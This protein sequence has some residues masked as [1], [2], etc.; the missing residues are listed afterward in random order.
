[1]GGGLTPA[2][3]RARADPADQ[4]TAVGEYI[5]TRAS[6]FDAQIRPPAVTATPV[7]GSAGAG[8]RTDS[9]D[10]AAED[11]GGAVNGGG[12][13]DHPLRTPQA[14]CDAKDKQHEG[15]L[16]TIRTLRDAARAHHAKHPVE[17][18]AP[19]ATRHACRRFKAK[20][21][22]GLDQWT[23]KEISELSDEAL[24]ELG[25]LLAEAR[26]TTALPAQA[27]CNLLTLLGKKT[28]ATEPSP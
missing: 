23:F 12:D 8:V 2:R 7:H 4:A 14:R 11:L 10:G 17:P 3:V 15:V 13:N 25:E 9:G 22:I 6:T 19:G 26:T 21:S 18:Y 28:A 5:D 20:T 27:M 16:Y 1:M 24:H